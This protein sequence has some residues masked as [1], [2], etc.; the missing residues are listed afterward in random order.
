MMKTAN[1]HLATIALAVVALASAEA[2]AAAP[3]GA[4]AVAAGASAGVDFGI[5]TPAPAAQEAKAVHAPR[6]HISHKGASAKGR[7]STAKPYNPL[8]VD[9][10]IAVKDTPAKEI[11]L[12]GVMKVQ[13]ALV[14][15]LDPSRAH[16]ISYADGGVQT[17]YMSIN[18]PNRIELPF[19]NAHTIHRSSLHIDKG[20]GQSIYVY[21]DQL[22]ASEETLFVEPMDGG[23]VLG[24][25]IV[26][27][28]IPA[29]TLIVADD[30][31]IVGGRKNPARGSD[32]YVG[33]VQDLMEAGALNHTPN[34]YSRVALTL[35]AI[36]M[37]G[38]TVTADRRF[39]GA[40]DDVYVYT[41]RNLGKQPQTLTED[42]F[43]G[44]NVMA[45]SI[46]PRPVLQP[47][48]S[49]RVIVLARKRGEQ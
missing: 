9:P 6:R 13:G 40:E 24:L 10:A 45:V 18:A 29:Q 22:P 48:E 37:N 44:A 1:Y 34:G 26:P 25:D 15:A 38:L 39:S 32:E 46:F 31:G 19:A 2:Y 33:H 3:T 35:P 17:V 21:W 23:P 36:A 20:T 8:A 41:A 42:E 16:K 11:D 5:S 30:A 28:D 47:G 14:D 7:S 43:D 49:T 27:K 4:P 12:P